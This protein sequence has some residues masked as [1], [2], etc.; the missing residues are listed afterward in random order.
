MITSLVK[1]QGHHCPVHQFN[2]NL[3]DQ[4]ALS[5]G[6]SR[7]EMA[8]LEDPVLEQIRHRLGSTLS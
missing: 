1:K 3:S 6:A 4:R 8:G 2:L 5:H 7:A